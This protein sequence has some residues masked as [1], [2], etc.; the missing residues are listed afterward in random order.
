MA[1]MAT[2]THSWWLI[3]GG[4]ITKIGLAL[5]SG[6]D[7]ALVAK[8]RASFMWSVNCTTAFQVAGG[9]IAGLVVLTA[10][11]RCAMWV[12]VG[13]YLAMLVPAFGIKTSSQAQPR[14][15]NFGHVAWSLRRQPHLLSLVVTAAATSSLVGLAFFC[16][17]LFY[18]RVR[19]G[20]AQLPSWG[21]GYYWAI[22]MA[23]PLV[24][25]KVRSRMT[26][27]IGNYGAL[28]VAVIVGA[29]CLLAMGS[30][31]SIWGLILVLGI[32]FG[33]KLQV[34]FLLK[35]VAIRSEQAKKGDDLATIMSLLVM[36]ELAIIGVL[37]WV[38]SSVERA[39][40]LP[41]A[42]R[43]TGCLFAALAGTALAITMRTRPRQTTRG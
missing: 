27:K 1:F 41:V 17:P 40:G 28:I 24:I 21:Y 34:P 42:L 22:C 33:S 8:V 16:A 29:G 26:T 43:C 12:Q 32:V 18:A 35:E 7:L 10:G 3:M 25:G 31:A 11:I 20:G 13:I 39:Y 38:T 5:A 19:W 9:L 23:S 2:A 6:V 14:K 30:A 4:I 15:Q 36:V 37:L